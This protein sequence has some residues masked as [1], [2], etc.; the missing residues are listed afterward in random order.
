MSSPRS[1]SDLGLYSWL[2]LAALAC[3]PT[4][5]A[6][7]G[8]STASPAHVSQSQ[9]ALR[10]PRLADD[11][12]LVHGAWAD[13]S[14][15]SSV[16]EAL[17]RD[18]YTVRALQLREQSLADDAALVRHAIDTLERPVVVVGHSYGGFVSSEASAG[19]DNVVGLVFIA[20]FAPDQGESLAALT[21]PYPTPAIANLQI[22]DQGNTIIEPSAFVRHFASDLPAREA[23]VL[24]AVQHPTA[25][26]ILAAA[27]G[28]PGWRT[29]PSYFQVS[30][31]DEVI[32][33]QLQRFFAKR[34]Q[35]QTIELR[36]SHVSLISKPRQVANL[37][38]RAA[39]GR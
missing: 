25:R 3:S 20:A 23:R 7:D 14:C 12:L 11:I 30:T 38:Q 9:T 22:D 8:S 4:D 31:D 13:G 33:P 15:W 34:M 24:A 27:A 10:P 37:I 26:S 36:A 29:I 35:A 39:S 5:G 16:I 32:A 6:L 2:T 21:Q 19:A 18:G 17:Q 28:E 1:L